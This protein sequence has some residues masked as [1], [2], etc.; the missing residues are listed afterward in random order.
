M[1]RLL[2]IAA[3][4]LVAAA[5]APAP[6]PEF[7][8]NYRLWMQLTLL[9]D[10]TAESGKVFTYAVHGSVPA[11]AVISLSRKEEKWSSFVYW[12]NAQAKY[13]VKKADEVRAVKQKNDFLKEVAAVAGPSAPSWMTSKDFPKG[14]TPK[15]LER[16]APLAF[17]IS[18]GSRSRGSLFKEQVLC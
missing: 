5:P 10:C 17:L 11:Q 12:Q 14:C 4:A 6:N 7:P 15:T 1:T 9:A 18:P 2:A 16:K 3:L 8:K 13:F